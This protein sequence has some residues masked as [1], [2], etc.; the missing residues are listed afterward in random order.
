[1]SGDS[2]PANSLVIR[3][4]Y[5]LVLDAIGILLAL[6]SGILIRYESL[7]RFLTIVV[8]HWPLLVAAV[9]LRI[10]LYWRMGLYARLWRY[11]SIRDVLKIVQASIIGSA[12]LILVNFAL[13]PV[14]G[15]MPLPSYSV[16]VV[17]WVLNLGGLSFSRLLLRMLLNWLILHQ[18]KDVIEKLTRHKRVLIAGAGDVGAIVSRLIQDNPHM[19]FRVIGYVDDD[20]AKQTMYV[21]GMPVL[22]TRQDLPD[23]V[24]RHKIDEVIVAMPTAPQ[25]VID[26]IVEKSA[27]V[28]VRARV[29]PGIHDLLMG[30][31]S[32]DQL[33]Q[34][35][36]P[37][38]ALRTNGRPA[39]PVPRPIYRSLLVT[40]GAGF[41]GSNFV[42]YMLETHPNY[43]IVVYDKLTY[44]GNLDNLLGLKE[45]YPG[46]YVFVKGDICDYNEVALAMKL[47]NIDAIVNFAAESHVD[48][49]LMDPDSF[50]RTNVYGTYTLLEAA[51][52]FGVQ[53]FHQVSTDEVYGQI[54][55]G[56]FSEED[57][58]ETRS[59]YS[60]SKAAADLLVHAYHVSFGVP[61]TITRGSNNIG[62][63][64]Y[65]EKA[66]PLFITNAIDNQPLPVYGDGLY[67]RDYQYVIDHCRAIDVVL[68]DGAVGEIYNA[69]GGNE[70]T[71]LDLART[72]LKR[73][74]K[75][76]SLIRLVA[77]RPGQDR[78]YSLN[79]SKLKAL[80]WAPQ[81]D[82]ERAV[83]DTIQ[84]YL[85][86]EWWWRKIK[87]GEY[88]QYY[89]KQFSKR[90]ETA[91]QA[92]LMQ[93]DMAVRS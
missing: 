62:P 63:Y 51:R 17:D 25:R 66:L 29:I 24:V 83:D 65:P 55:R 87:S 81:W 86:N 80:G 52:Q 60:A 15:W 41:I 37:D 20:P 85:A 19:G 43:M 77:D 13:L 48:R 38:V 18:K 40:G 78:R 8:S 26:E 79:C 73:L 4:R 33:R 34:W 28:S 16:F 64:Q 72:V 75:P 54:I 68:H 84:W 31:L 9:V 11:T 32:V 39:S 57:P 53:R 67:V 50:L 92:T 21:N 23:L 88:R 6:G 90:L 3:M 56:S 30:T 10:P 69:G 49:S 47:Y 1:M 93:P 89:E 27:S 82:F 59:P 35:R 45:K 2:R 42:R 71:A 91:V 76:E 22:G 61:T 58:L 7:E 14:F 36:S 5:L 74:G 44:A 12:L 70:V 46:R